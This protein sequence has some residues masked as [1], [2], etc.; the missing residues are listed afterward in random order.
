MKPRFHPLND[1]QQEGLEVSVHKDYS[2]KTQK[3]GAEKTG[4][5]EGRRV[6]GGKLKTRQ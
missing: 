5:E 6:F 2:V 3:A 4:R 1:R